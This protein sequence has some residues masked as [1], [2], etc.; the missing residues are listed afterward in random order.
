MRDNLM[1]SGFPLNQRDEAFIGATTRPPINADD[2]VRSILFAGGTGAVSI[3]GIARR[4]AAEGRSFE[5]HHFARSADHARLHEEFD[6]LRSHGKV[7]HYFDL[8]DDLFAQKSAHA[9][10]PTHASTQIWCSG[11]PAFMDLVGR[12]AS[13]WVYASNI[14]R[15]VLDERTA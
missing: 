4:L 12:Q 7:C 6:A 3:A 11:P 2:R 10:S 14:H 1:L 15:I 9:M 8:S 13:E 5:V